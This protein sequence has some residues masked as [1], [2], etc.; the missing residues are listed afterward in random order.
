MTL[1][2]HV[3]GRLELRRDG[4]DVELPPQQAL[5]L[6]M[7][8]AAAGRPVHPDVLARGLWGRDLDALDDATYRSRMRTALPALVSNLRRALAPDARI[9]PRSESGG[10]YLLKIE[11]DEVDCLRFQARLAEAEQ[12]RSEGNVDGMLAKLASAEREWQGPPFDILEL[13]GPDAAAPV[14]AMRDQLV[15][16]FRRMCETWA[17]VAARHGLHHELSDRLDGWLRDVPEAAML[18][19]V[20]FLAALDKEDAGSAR[21]VL[22]LWDAV[23]SSGALSHERKQLRERAGLLLDLVEAGVPRA[24]P[25]AIPS[26]DPTPL[27]GREQELRELSRFVAGVA[28]GNSGVLLL[29]GEG[30]MG[31]TRLLVELR[32]LAAEREVRTAALV[33]EEGPTGLGPWRDLLGPLWT[34]ALRDLSMGN[35]VTVGA[36][37]LLRALTEAPAAPR[38]PEPDIDRQLGRL[39]EPIVTLLRH[40]ARRPLVIILDDV[41]RIDVAS[42][43]LLTASWTQ[44]SRIEVSIGF[45]AAMRPADLNPKGPTA[46]WRGELQRSPLPPL[47]VPPLGRR[48][49]QAWLTTIGGHANPD[50]AQVELALERTGGRPLLL[51]HVSLEPETGPS[52]VFALP[53]EPRAPLAVRRVLTEALRRRGRPC[54]TWLEAAAVAATGQRFDPATVA[55]MLSPQFSAA[56][57]DRCMEEAHRAR[58]VGPGGR[59]FEND[60]WRDVILD[61]LPAARLRSLHVQ[62]YQAL[63]DEAGRHGVVIGELAVRLARH[64]LEGQERLAGAEV[65]DAA[66][67]AARTARRRSAYELAIDLCQRALEAAEAPHHFDLLVE[68]GDAQHDAGEIAAAHA[69]YAEA[70]DVAAGF[71]DADRQVLAALRSA[72]L[73]WVPF[74]ANQ[75]LCERLEAALDVLPGDATQLRAELEAHLARALAPEGEDLRRRQQLARSALRFVD[76]VDDPDVQ[77]ELLIGGRW[78]LFETEPPEKLLELA[79]RLRRVSSRTGSEY[80][81]G[82]ALIGMI[83][84]LLRLGRLR[85]ARVVIDEHR[86]RAERNRRPLSLYLQRTLE[87]MTALWEGDFEA[88]SESLGRINE[89]MLRPNRALPQGSELTIRQLVT[90]QTGWL[91]REQG[92]PEVLVQVEETVESMVEQTAD[93][94]MWRAALALLHC[95][96]GDIGRAA[97]IVDAIVQEYAGLEQ[98]PPYGWAVPTL[99]LLAEIC[100]ELGAAGAGVE[101]DLDLAQLAP[102]LSQLLRP[103]LE[104]FALGGTPAVIVGPVTRAAGLAS[105]TSGEV[106]DAIQLLDAAARHPATRG[107]RPTQAR[108]D[109]DRARAYLARDRAG[110]RTRAT[111]QLERAVRSGAALGMRRLTRRAQELLDAL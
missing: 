98:F 24:L 43:Q 101:Q 35:E 62:A 50:R 69:S 68:R 72:R 87:A 57:L 65:V 26:T 10:G 105:L 14:Q 40:S 25:S 55:S 83:V 80:F 102:R 82:E 29:E 79:E 45:V 64:A 99:F 18:W 19:F 4:R 74:F 108:L 44:L 97:E 30:G 23:G 48:D 17:A 107:A 54:R 77:C 9:P 37:Q 92:V 2:L 3:L 78:G 104:E 59:Q 66:L 89:E 76:Q 109:F 90:A 28:E 60:L 16:D 84:D 67:L 15:A 31:K 46:R 73:W 52:H 95:E 75:D 58:I 22:R 12:L 7:L 42:L 32:R 47:E 88:A 53:S 110:D 63:R 91:L 11:P 81:H 70:A 41:H 38:A 1:D 49:V 85:Q 96:T 61:Q 56:S 94:P 103:H 8:V 21:R 34:E 20:R 5:V 27:V 93:S 106:A 36:A 86:K 111:T 71:G 51:E 39:V 100:D 13:E 33:C 6:V